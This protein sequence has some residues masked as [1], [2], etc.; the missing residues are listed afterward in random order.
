MPLWRNRLALVKAEST[1]GT[2]SAP[3]NT[4]ALLFTEL[5]VEPLALELIERETIQ[6]YMGHRASIVGQRSVPFKATA[7]M[8]G[9][10][11]AGTAPRWG[12]L[13]KAS[14]CSETI[15]GGTV[16]YTPVSSGFSSYT[17]DFYADNGSQQIITGIRGSAEISM[18]VG[19]IPT[20][21]F[22]HMGIYGAPTALSLPTPTYTN[23]AA[24]VAVNADNT[25]TVSVHGF[26]A[27]M[28]EF[29]LDLGVEMTFEQK[30]GCSKQVRI[31]QIKPTGS[32]TIELPAF[33]TKDFLTI[34]SN[35]TTGT[36]TWV[37]GG[38]AGNIITFTAAQCAFDSPTLDDGDSVTHITLP[39]R[40]LPNSSGTSVF[41]LA[42]T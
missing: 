29:S 33:A 19:E 22:D 17:A 5:D 1:Y 8:A 15:G 13:M 40:C 27:C 7:E 14:G 9:S 28:T 32:I 34:A 3:A 21:A 12:P 36:I 30:A 37:H 24:P 35:Q 6:A 11:T 10:G 2:S 38:T 41:S 42:L 16:T 31:T 39:F 26:S 4:D 20:I 18:S 25:A 23:Q